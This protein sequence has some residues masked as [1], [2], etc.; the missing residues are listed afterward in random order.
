MVSGS[1]ICTP[2][3][4]NIRHP[5]EGANEAFA[6]SGTE[7]PYRMP[8]PFGEGQGTLCLPHHLGQSPPPPKQARMSCSSHHHEDGL[9]LWVRWLNGDQKYVPF[10][11]LLGGGQEQEHSQPPWVG[12][13]GSRMNLMEG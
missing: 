5:R 3:P 9:V 10:L 13:A 8:R 7:T 12:G 11:I 2:P 4:A 1:L 6:T